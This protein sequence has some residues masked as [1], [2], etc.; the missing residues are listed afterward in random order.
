[1][2]LIKAKVKTVIG[3]TIKTPSQDFHVEKHKEP[4]Y[5]CELTERE[6]LSLKGIELPKEPEW[7]N[8]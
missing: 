3:K 2:K 7:R 6:Y 1:M 5:I 8:T 4:F